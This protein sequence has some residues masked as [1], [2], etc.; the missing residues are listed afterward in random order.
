MPQRRPRG[1]KKKN[2]KAKTKDK[3][4]RLNEYD[5]VNGQSVPVWSNEEILENNTRCI[6]DGDWEQ[7]IVRCTWHFGGKCPHYKRGLFRGKN[8]Q[9]LLNTIYNDVNFDFIL[10]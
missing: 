6:K 10:N 2:K 3:N 1:V 8:V 9:N 7:L 4:R 5:L